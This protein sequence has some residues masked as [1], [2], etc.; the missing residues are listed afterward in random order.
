MIEIVP[1]MRMESLNLIS[2][3]VLTHSNPLCSY[4]YLDYCVTSVIMFIY[5]LTGGFW[6]FPSANSNPSTSLACSGFEEEREMHY[7]TSR[8]DVSR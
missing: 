1:N 4:T 3:L 2:V 8:V 6:P 5:E 7:S